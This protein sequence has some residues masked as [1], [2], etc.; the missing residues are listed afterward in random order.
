M[1]TTLSLVLHLVI[2]IKKIH[3]TT[4]SRDR[5]VTP[6]RHGTI[7]KLQDKGGGMEMADNP[8]ETDGTSLVVNAEPARNIATHRRF[9]AI[10]GGM[11]RLLQPGIKLGTTRV[12]FLAQ[13]TVDLFRSKGEPIPSQ[14]DSGCLAPPRL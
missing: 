3:E 2:W 9:V 5:K 8:L 4:Q 13:K 1:Q 6:L 10:Q 14:V 12:A 7:Q 11:L